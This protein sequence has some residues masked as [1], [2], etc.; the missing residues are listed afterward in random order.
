VRLAKVEK[1]KMSVTLS[2]V[3]DI[4][5]NLVTGNR[6]AFFTNVADDAY[7][8]GEG[9]RPFAGHY[10]NKVDFLAHTFVACL[11]ISTLKKGRRRRCCR[12]SFIA[13]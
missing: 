6:E 4:F 7:W 3:Q 12:M 10:Q 11:L 13:R 1:F 9:T 8:T 5:K 2:Q